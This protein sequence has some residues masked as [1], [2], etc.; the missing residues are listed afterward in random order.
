MQ[1]C[2]RRY[3]IAIR[4]RGYFDPDVV[5]G[6]CEEHAS[7]THDHADRIWTLLMF[8]LWHREYLDVHDVHAAA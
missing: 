6:M 4:Q 8:E 3:A 1:A 7:G 2:V 5:K